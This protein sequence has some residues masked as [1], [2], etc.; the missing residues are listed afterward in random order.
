MA[1]H[2][3]ALENTVNNMGTLM[4]KFLICPSA[5]YIAVSVM[6][7]IAGCCRLLQGVAVCCLVLQCVAV[8]C[9]VL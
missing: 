7:C 1:A 8:C 9:S 5:V 4:P 6:Q 3:S 2:C